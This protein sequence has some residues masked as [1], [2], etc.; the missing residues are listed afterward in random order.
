MTNRPYL[1]NNTLI[2]DHYHRWREMVLAVAR[3]DGFLLAHVSHQGF[4]ADLVERLAEDPWWKLS[5]V[6]VNPPQ[7]YIGWHPSLPKDEFFIW[8]RHRGV[9]TPRQFWGNSGFGRLVFRP[10]SAEGVRPWTTADI[11]DGVLK[12]WEFDTPETT[13]MPEEA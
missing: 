9:T 1:L 8:T 3:H 11:P 12:E 5:P 7:N 13:P 10:I 2:E 4:Y 6:G